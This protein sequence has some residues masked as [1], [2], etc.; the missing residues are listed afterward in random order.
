MISQLRL[1][2]LLM[3]LAGNAQRGTFFR[4][5]DLQWLLRGT[6]LSAIG[7]RIRGGRY[8]RKGAFEALYIANTQETALYETEAIY[9]R[10][11]IVV[12]DRQPPRVMLSLDYQLIDIVDLRD[13]SVLALLGVT[14]DELKAPWKQA[15]AENRPVLTQRIGAAARAVDVEALLVPSARVDTGTNLVI[16]PDRLRKG[17]TVELFVGAEPTIPRYKLEGQY[18]STIRVAR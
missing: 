7:S 11:G 18:E 6:P 9:E 5:I 15:Q 12:A 13:P 17:S 14:V 2:R 3:S 8:N 10:A 4:S 1:E 16:F